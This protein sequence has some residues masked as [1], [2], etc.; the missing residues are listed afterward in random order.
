MRIRCRAISYDNLVFETDAVEIDQYKMIEHLR[1]TR[2]HEVVKCS[3]DAVITRSVIPKFLSYLRPLPLQPA[4]D[5]FMQAIEVYKGPVFTSVHTP[6]L[7]ELA[8]SEDDNVVSSYDDHR[9]N[10]TQ[11]LELAADAIRRKSDDYLM[12]FLQHSDAITLPE[13]YRVNHIRD[14]SPPTRVSC[15]LFGR[16]RHFTRSETQQETWQNKINKAEKSILSKDIANFLWQLTK[17]GKGITDGRQM[18]DSMEEDATE[19]IF[20][21][22]F[23]EGTN[24][25]YNLE[26][27][28]REVSLRRPFVSFSAAIFLNYQLLHIQVNDDCTELSRA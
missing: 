2:L 14:C 20:K 7:D 4:I 17:Y 18:P 27:I 15:N 22:E 5:S 9:L 21:S 8:C 11:D 3:S 10:Y 16:G 6:D 26:D 28:C 23:L 13:C 24:E 1:P 12:N 19:Y 25:H